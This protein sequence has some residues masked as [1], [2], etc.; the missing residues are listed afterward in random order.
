M[1]RLK[2]TPQAGASTGRNRK[3]PL[4]APRRV[5]VAACGVTL[6]CFSWATS[7][8]GTDARAPGSPTPAEDL[9]RIQPKALPENKF[10]AVLP[11]GATFE[12]VGVND[13]LENS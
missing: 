10:R 9:A 2:L 4:P 3:V 11:D 5:S 8:T 13:V 1:T 7:A 6:V 12:L